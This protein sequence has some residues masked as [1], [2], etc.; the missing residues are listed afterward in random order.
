LA[1]KISEPAEPLLEKLEEFFRA[2][3]KALWGESF[4]PDVVEAVLAAGFDD[5]WA[6]RKRLE[7]L[8]GSVGRGDFLPLA[9]AFKRAVSILEK[10]PADRLRGEVDAEKLVEEAERALW[11]AQM[12]VRRKVDARLEKAEYQGALE[13]MASLKPAIDHFF[14]KV[15]VMADDIGVRENRFRLLVALRALFGEVADLSHIQGAEKGAEK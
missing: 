1:D 13:D 2:R 8:A 12:D 14:D 3:L 4:A 7:G 5:L 15:H 10:V 6:S 11:K 9:A